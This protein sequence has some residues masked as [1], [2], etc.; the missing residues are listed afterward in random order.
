MRISCSR[1]QTMSACGRQYRYRYVDRLQSVTLPF[2]LFFG[3]VVDDAVSGYVHAHAL[4]KSFDILAAYEQA[5]ETQLP[6]N[7]IQYPQHWDADIAKE[8]GHILCD[9]F[10]EVWEKSNLVAAVDQYGEPMVQ[11]RMIVPLPQNHELEAVIDAV[12]MSTV[13]GD[14]AVLDFKTTSCVMSPESPFG[15]NALQLTAYQYAVNHVY[16]AYMGDVAN[17]G[18]MEFHRKKPAKT[19]KGTGPTVYPPKFFEPRSEQQIQD[20]KQTFLWYIRDI[21]GQRFHR[22]TN[23]A[24]NN[25]C[26]MCDF[27]RLCVHGDMQGITTRQR[28]HAN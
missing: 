20:M 12:V 2:P 24:F 10:P 22:P 15:A 27:S 25:P 13:S 1:A 18:F 14:L 23:N 17:I 16:R 6:K 21:A 28:R 3:R 11:K 4:G 26:D 5:F 19:A 7:D 9:Q 8:V